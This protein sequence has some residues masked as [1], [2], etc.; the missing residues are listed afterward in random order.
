MTA[1]DALA[2]VCAWAL[3]CIIGGIVIILLDELIDRGNR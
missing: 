3:G 2:F 1:L